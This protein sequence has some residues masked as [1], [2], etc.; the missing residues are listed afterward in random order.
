MAEFPS[1]VVCVESDDLGVYSLFHTQVE[2]GGKKIDCLYNLMT[3]AV[4]RSHL[5]GATF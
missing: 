5:L 3:C 1:N 2:V 4:E